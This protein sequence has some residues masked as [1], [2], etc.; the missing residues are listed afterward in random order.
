MRELNGIEVDGNIISVTV[1]RS[2]NNRFSGESAGND[3]RGE[4]FNARD[5][6][7]NDRAPRPVARENDFRDR[8]SRP[9]FYNATPSQQERPFEPS[10]PRFP[11]ARRPPPFE[12]N[13]NRPPPPRVGGPRD[14]PPRGPVGRA[15]PPRTTVPAGVVNRPPPRAA[16]FRGPSNRPPPPRF[17]VG[18]DIGARPPVGR[19]PSARP[20]AFARTS[21]QSYGRRPFTER[22]IRAA[23]PP[24]PPPPPVR[25]INRRRRAGTRGTYPFSSF[26]PGM[27]GAGGNVMWNPV[28]SG[29]YPQNSMFMNPYMFNMGGFG[30]MGRG[31]G[32]MMRGGGRMRTVN[33][34][35]VYKP[36]NKENNDGK[37]EGAINAKGTGANR[38]TTSSSNMRRRG[39]G[40]RSLPVDRSGPLSDTI[41]HVSNID[42][43]MNQTQFGK[44]FD[45]YKVKT[46][47]LMP[48]NRIGQNNLGFGLVELETHEEQERLLKEKPEIEAFGRTLYLHAALANRRTGQGRNGERK[49]KEGN[50]ENN[51]NEENNEGL[52]NEKSDDQQKAGEEGETA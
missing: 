29:F 21:F 44:L 26:R 14:L 34:R 13:K 48:T 36:G 28:M 49:E 45:G 6:Q 11:A 18:R 41:V 30:R 42:R 23:P 19:A 15:P 20:N 10:G 17:P 43:R 40:R 52:N 47:I 4:S 50:G 27:R 7:R 31:R 3:F 25:D 24:P 12:G 39:R 33:P 1:A 37:T 5:F 9:G 16:P 32:R 46:A 38:T 2:Q 35:N 51:E 8:R 22:R